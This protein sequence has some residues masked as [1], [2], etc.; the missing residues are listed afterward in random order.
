MAQPTDRKIRHRCP[1]FFCDFFRGPLAMSCATSGTFSPAPPDVIRSN[2]CLIA[3]TAIRCD[4]MQALS[5]EW[6]FPR[7]WRRSFPPGLLPSNTF[8]E[9][10]PLL[11]F[12]GT[13]ISRNFSTRDGAEGQDFFLRTC[14]KAKGECPLGS[15][16]RRTKGKLP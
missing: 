15:I 10:S 2:Y 1:R 12:W 16:R 13:S 7:L 8:P 6:I 11:S 5:L 3:V 4:L 9:L 14:S